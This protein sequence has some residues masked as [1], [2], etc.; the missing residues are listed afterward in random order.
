MLFLDPNTLFQTGVQLTL[1]ATAALVWLAPGLE[2]L[3]VP[4]DLAPWRRNLARAV[5]TSVAA[6]LATA[7]ILAWSMGTV[8]WI[9]IPAGIL[10]SG[11]FS[12][13]FL[14][15]LAVVALGPLPAAW[16][17]G[18]AGA[19]EFC[20]RV[21]LE[22]ALRVGDWDGG[23]FEVVRP[24]VA[25]MFVWSVAMILLAACALGNLSLIHISEPTRPY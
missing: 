1:A 13:G 10:A 12:A 16:S 6:T 22:I 21:V 8:P 14:A 17:E 9:G 15:S 7:P 20:A 3:L 23:W 25:E 19:A 24:S 4:R 18:F 11:F 2:T 5:T